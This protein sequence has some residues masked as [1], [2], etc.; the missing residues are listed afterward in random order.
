MTADIIDFFISASKPLLSKHSF[1]YAIFF[2]LVLKSKVEYWSTFLD[3]SVLS[4]SSFPEITS[5]IKDASL[6]L[7]ANGPIWSKDDA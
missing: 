3:D 7:F 6:T 1:M 4:N 2:G 5:S